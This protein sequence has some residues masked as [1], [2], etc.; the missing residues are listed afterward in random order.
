MS[1]S[2]TSLVLDEL[3]AEKLAV[4]K[5]FAQVIRKHRG[6]SSNSLARLANLAFAE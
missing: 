4:V 3:P 6:Q 1:K 5:E 2:A